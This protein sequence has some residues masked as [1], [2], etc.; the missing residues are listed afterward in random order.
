MW[1]YDRELGF[2]GWGLKEKRP[3]FQIPKTKFKGG[4]KG[5]F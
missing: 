1:N 3:K 5:D 4:K 2:R